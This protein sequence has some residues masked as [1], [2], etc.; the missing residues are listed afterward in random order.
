MVDYSENMSYEIL[1]LI[2][3]KKIYECLVLRLDGGYFASSSLERSEP[4]IP[5]GNKEKIVAA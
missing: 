3:Y 1:Y 5:V 4:V 2:S